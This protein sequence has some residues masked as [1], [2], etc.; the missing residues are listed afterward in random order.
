MSRATFD[1]RCVAGLVAL[2]VAP[3][4]EDNSREESD[5]NVSEDVVDVEAALCL[6][7]HCYVLLLWLSCNNLNMEDVKS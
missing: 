2:N 4:E 6:R 3:G 5:A 1:Q 7:E